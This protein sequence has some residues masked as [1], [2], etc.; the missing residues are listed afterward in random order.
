MSSTQAGSAHNDPVNYET[1]D[2]TPVT[3]DHDAEATEFA[4]TINKIV[5]A[6]Y[7]SSKPKLQE[8]VPF[9]SYNS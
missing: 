4:K 8:P 2:E 1:P 7:S 5:K 3:T 6:N 9:D